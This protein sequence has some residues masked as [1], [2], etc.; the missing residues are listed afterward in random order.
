MH[1]RSELGAARTMRRARSSDIAHTYLGL[2]K[3]QYDSIKGDDTHFQEEEKNEL[4]AFEK[5]VIT[6]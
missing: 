6:F 2:G 1:A 3:W 5:I 4:I